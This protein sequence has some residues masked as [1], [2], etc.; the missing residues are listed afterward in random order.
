MASFEYIALD[1]KGEETTGSI[2]ASDEADAIKQLRSTGLYPTQVAASGKGGGVSGAAKRR[3][4]KGQRARASG[5]GRATGRVK[6][7]ILM[8]FT[9]QLATLVSAGLPLLRGLTVLGNQEKNKVMQRTVNSLA[10]SVQGGGTFSESLG[11]H[12][13]V[14]DKLYVNMVKAGELGGVLELVLERLAEYMEKAQK[15]KNRIV[16]AMVYPVIVIVIAV[17][18]VIF[19]M[20]VIVPKFE[21]IFEDMLGGKALPGITQF[22]INIS[23]WIQAYVLWIIVGLAVGYGLWKVFC[24]Q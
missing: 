21:M 15:L 20:V 10:D 2:S 22:V 4:K 14:F 23:R 24:R 5:R 8:I 18:I 12:P 1:S 6:S 13:R 7:K 3:A 11:Q 17:A 9:R 19:L 16:A